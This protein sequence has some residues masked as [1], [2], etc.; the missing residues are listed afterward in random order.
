QSSGD[1]DSSSYCPPITGTATVQ[2]SPKLADGAACTEPAAC[3]SGG[4]NNG[5]CGALVVANA[6]V[7]AGQFL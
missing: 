5:T 1:C 2:C 6:D 4:C 7:C 3:L